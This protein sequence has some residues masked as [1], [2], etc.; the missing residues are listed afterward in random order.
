M[1]GLVVCIICVQVGGECQMSDAWKLEYVH[2][3]FFL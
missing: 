1:M 2:V 3:E